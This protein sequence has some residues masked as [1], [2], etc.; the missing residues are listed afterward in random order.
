MCNQSKKN[1][2]FINKQHKRQETEIYII[3]SMANNANE[4]E[5]LHFSL[6][7]LHNIDYLP[8]FVY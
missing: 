2:L 7:N 1:N 5:N 6:I 3:L 4:K 8:T